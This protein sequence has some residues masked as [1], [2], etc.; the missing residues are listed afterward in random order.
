MA[1]VQAKQLKP[2]VS[3]KYSLV[4]GIG[5]G[6]VHFKGQKIQLDQIGL[7]EADELVKQGIDVLV[8]KPA[9]AKA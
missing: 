8:S 7:K 9:A 3:A 4:P 6:E 1:E 5:V 2:E